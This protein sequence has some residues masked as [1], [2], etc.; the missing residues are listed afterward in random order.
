MPGFLRSCS[1]CFVHPLFVLGSAAFCA[2][3][4]RSDLTHSPIHLSMYPIVHNS[5]P[6]LPRK[7]P[8]IL[9]DWAHEALIEVRWGADAAGPLQDRP[10]IMASRAFFGVQVHK[11]L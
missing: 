7:I 4:T 11:F 6:R 9:S 2:F 5:T 3:S 1:V 10:Q 8:Q